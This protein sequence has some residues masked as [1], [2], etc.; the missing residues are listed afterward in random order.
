MVRDVESGE[1]RDVQRVDGSGP[2][3]HLRHGLVHEGGGAAN[4]RGVGITP[5]PILLPL[6]LDG[7]RALRHRAALVGRG[8]AEPRI[9][10]IDLADQ[11]IDSF[12]GVLTSLVP[13]G[14]VIC[15]LEVL[16]ECVDVASR[17]LAGIR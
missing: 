2:I 17:K 5:N 6:N 13:R 14:N 4:R 8:R 1:N 15:S 7:N 10:L 9:Q 12:G 16:G 3:P 11:I